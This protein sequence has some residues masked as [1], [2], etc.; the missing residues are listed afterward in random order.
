MPQMRAKMRVTGVEVSKDSKNEVTLAERV[1]F[2]AVSKTDG[3]ESDGLDE[4]NTYAKFSPDGA[5]SILIANP[6]LFGQFEVDQKYYV[7][8]TPA[9]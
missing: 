3:Y 9:V 1:N 6:Q 7:D 5:C 8:F 4:D 2:A